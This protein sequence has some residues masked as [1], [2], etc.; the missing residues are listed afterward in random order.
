MVC[1]MFVYAEAES[2]WT[3]KSRLIAVEEKQVADNFPGWL[4]SH[5]EPKA[6]T[7]AF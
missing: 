2:L 6:V 7:S 4:A 5:H 3:G 1:L